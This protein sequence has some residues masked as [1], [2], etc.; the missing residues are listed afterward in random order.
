MTKNTIVKVVV[1]ALA[2][3]GVYTIIKMRK[4]SAITPPTTPK[5]GDAKSFAGED[6]FFDFTG[7]RPRG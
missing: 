4:P 3:Y 7:T 6:M 2:L 5:V 1:G